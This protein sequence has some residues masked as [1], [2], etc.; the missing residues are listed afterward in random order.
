[1][2]DKVVIFKTFSDLKSYYERISGRACQNLTDFLNENPHI[3]IISLNKRRIIIENAG[4]GKEYYNLDLIFKVD[5]KYCEYKDY[6]KSWE[7]KNKGY[8]N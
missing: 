1:M 4:N 7:L 5:K 3:E 6:S 2:E 8:F